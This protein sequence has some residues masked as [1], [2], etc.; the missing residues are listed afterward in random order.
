MTTKQDPP[1]DDVPLVICEGRD[2]GVEM[3]A[4]IYNNEFYKKKIKEFEKKLKVAK[5]K[6]TEI[7]SLCACDSMH[8]EERKAY[9]HA[10]DGLEAL[11][12]Q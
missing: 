9:N 5:D 12:K 4:M 2:L 3:D 1:R 6:L 8:V 7:K 11:N 10:K